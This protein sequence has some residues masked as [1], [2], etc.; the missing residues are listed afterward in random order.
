LLKINAHAVLSYSLAGVALM[1][2]LSCF[3][4]YNPLVFP[5]ELYGMGKD[6]L[7]NVQFLLG[8]TALGGH[9]WHASISRA[10]VQAKSSR[11]S[12]S[13]APAAT[14]PS[15]TVVEK[16]IQGSSED[17]TTTKETPQGDADVSA[18][19]KAEETEAKAEE[20][21]TKDP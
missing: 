15:S 1:A 21:E 20:T 8:L 3:F 4:L 12:E 2:F 10:V 13:K 19:A 14:K 16:E 17:V 11:A 6:A 7:A 18:E 9:V 5:P